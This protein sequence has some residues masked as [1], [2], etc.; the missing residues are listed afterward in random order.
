MPKYCSALRCKNRA[1]QVAAG[2]QRKVSFYPFPLHDKGRLQRWLQNMKQNNWYPSKHRVL[3][4]D[5]FTPDSFNIRWGIRYLKHNAVPTIFSALPNCQDSPLSPTNPSSTEELTEDAFEIDSSCSSDDFSPTSSN[6]PVTHIVQ[7]NELCVS[8]KS[9][10]FGSEQIAEDYQMPTCQIM[11]S[12]LDHTSLANILTSTIADLNAQCYEVCFE[13]QTTDSHETEW[14]STVELHNIKG[15]QANEESFLIN[16]ITQTIDQLKEHEQAVITIIVPDGVTEEQTLSTDSIVSD[17]QPST[18]L[19]SFGSS[20]DLDATSEIFGTE[21]SYCRPD[22]DRVNLWKKIT[23]LKSKID[24]LETQE[25]QTLSRLKSLEA[26]I[27][28]LQQDNLLSEEKLKIVE[29]CCNTF[30]FE[31]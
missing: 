2:K 3:C 30:E 1:G 31:T 26:I 11:T 23:K 25:S 16:T 15:I 14:P 19:E 17:E 10:E 22:L 7:P 4:S 18:N 28:Q 29:N 6:G 24:F 13:L 27:R 21:H 12:E 20:K 5:H 8:D 9:K